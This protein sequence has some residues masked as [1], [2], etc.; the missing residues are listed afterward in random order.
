MESVMLDIQSGMDPDEA[1]DKWI[2]ANA[3]TVDRWFE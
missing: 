3:K 1:A 2:K